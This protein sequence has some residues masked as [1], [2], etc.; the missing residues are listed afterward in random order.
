[1]TV[2]PSLSCRKYI[3]D[4][5]SVD[6]VDLAIIDLSLFDVP[7]GKEKIAT[8][9]Y[10]A[11][12]NIR[13]IYV[14]NFGLTQE[15][16]DAQYDIAESLFSLPDAEK[17]RFIA[18]L[19]KGEYMGYKPFG[20]QEVNPGVPENTEVC[21]IPKFGPGGVKQPHPQVLLDH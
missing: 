9:L 18:D 16:I 6:W 14:I 11:I 21:N 17:P 7:G 2:S 10:D 13:V 19:D 12:K 8:Q 3:T 1:M 5:F 20:L 15:K 4:I